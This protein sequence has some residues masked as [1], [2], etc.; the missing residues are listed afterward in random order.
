[1]SQFVHLHLHTEFS[2]SDS[3]VR[4]NRLIEK[5]VEEGVPALAI[6]DLNNLYGVVKFYKRCL[7]AGIKPLVGAEVWIE[8][9]YEPGTQDKGF[10]R[11]ET[12]I[13]KR[14]EFIVVKSSIII[15][16]FIRVAGCSVPGL[17]T[18]FN[19]VLFPG[20]INDGPF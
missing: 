7:A 18:K 15:L 6:T 4:I 20:I 2:L 3:T 1:M 5:A 12:K 10:I 13:G 11:I 9:P 14:N 17:C 19:I 8:N 16:V